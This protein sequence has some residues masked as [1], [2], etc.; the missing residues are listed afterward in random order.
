M[1]T[2]EI[3][4]N[5]SLIAFTNQNNFFR[6]AKGTD[7]ILANSIDNLRE[8]LESSNLLGISVFERDL[9]GNNTIH[10]YR[11]KILEEAIKLN[12]SFL[13]RFFIVRYILP[14]H[15]FVYDNNKRV[16]GVTV[17]RTK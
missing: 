15:E 3:N 8:R 14:K 6:E 7:M 9:I 12:D 4:D 11:D 5:I 17:Y 10:N 13:A 16:V 1:T 2:I